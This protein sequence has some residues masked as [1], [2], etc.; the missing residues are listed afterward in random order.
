MSATNILS[1][2]TC[3]IL[4]SATDLGTGAETYTGS[5]SFKADTISI[6]ETQSNADHSTAQDQFVMSRS[7]KTDWTMT[8]NTKLY[9]AALLAALRSNALA[10][11]V[12][13]APTGLGVT[14]PGLI[15]NIKV[16]Y[17]APST[18]SFSIKCHGVGLVYA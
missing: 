11:I 8:V 15:T 2:C 13:S 10:K 7:T 6:D 9:S 5:I 16:D 1:E 4:F 18:L 17:T 12:V 3:T 14:G